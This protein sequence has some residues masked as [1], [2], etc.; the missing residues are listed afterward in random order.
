[1]NNLGFM[2]Q[3][4]SQEKLLQFRM[5][6]ARLENLIKQRDLVANRLVEFEN[7]I[8]SIDE[9]T[10][11]KSD[12]AFHVGSDAFIPANPV[13]DGK[14]VVLIG[15]DVALEKSAADAKKILEGRKTEIGEAL[16]QIQKEVENTSKMLEG[17]VP[18]IEAM[19][20]H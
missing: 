16:K 7:T 2:T 9:V 1:M 5:L 3:K 13:A 18:E 10:K 14:L 6:E 15:A 12:V 8:A 17:M 20:G 4:D 19:H 11:A